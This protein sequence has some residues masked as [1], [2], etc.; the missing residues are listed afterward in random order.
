MSS[1]GWSAWW[2]DSFKPTSRSRRDHVV[3][4]FEKG[5]CSA[6]MPHG[7]KDLFRGKFQGQ[8][9]AL[10][11]SGKNK[12]EI[13]AELEEQLILADISLPVVN[14]LM[15]AIAAGTRNNDPRE[16][17]LALLRRELL[18]L[19]P[20]QPRRPWPTAAKTSCCWSGSTAAAR[21][22]APPSWPA[23]SR[24]AAAACCWP[25][26]TPSAPPAPPSSRCGAKSWASRSSAANAAPTPARSY[27]TPCSPGRAAISTC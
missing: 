21:P 26:P 10:F 11:A 1:P 5:R 24:S 14:R 13:L 3:I 16:E 22:P 7:S 25:R 27:S 15:A 2:W 6:I 17:F 18:A 4:L 19:F 23:I 20:K 12:E 9:A 8:M